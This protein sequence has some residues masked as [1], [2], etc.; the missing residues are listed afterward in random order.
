MSWDVQRG[1]EKER[2][3]VSIVTPSYNQGRFIE[4]NILSVKLQDYPNV[5]H[6]IVD[7][8]STD[9]T[10]EIL[11]KYE[12]TYNL[13][14]VSEPDKGQ[15]DAVNKGFAIAKGEIIGWLNSDDVYFDKGTISAVVKAF[16]QWPEADIIYGDVVLINEHS[17]I[18]KV[19]CFPRFSYARMLRGDYIGQPASF[20]RRRV[21]EQNKL[22]KDLHFVM[23]YEYWLRLGKHYN[24][25]HI[26]RVLAGD[27]NHP[28]RKILAQRDV[29]E[30]ER[31]QVM[32]QYGQNFGFRYY[33]GRMWDKI[34][35]G[36]WG[37][38]LGLRYLW[39]LSPETS[40]ACS[41]IL[42]RNVRLLINQLWRKNKQLL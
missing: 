6:I 39:D 32:R 9:E 5:E 7:G 17:V 22:N 20:F 27:R 8:G 16:N 41:I 38:I 3:L 2:P 28:N 30:A 36:A 25:V 31:K 13:R 29:M 19:Q 4:E 24:F 34:T 11:K 12:G 26:N 42:N 40:F 21:I 14:W 35:A 10:L 18:L 15:A 33:F 23:D 1:R 37:R